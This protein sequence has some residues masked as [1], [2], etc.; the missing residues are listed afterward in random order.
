MGDSNLRIEGYAPR[1][2][3]GGGAGAVFVA[4]R[5]NRAQRFHVL[6]AAIDAADMDGAQHALT[7][8]LNFDPQL[9]HDADFSKLMRAVHDKHTY[10]AQH[11]AHEYQAKLAH[12]LEVLSSHAPHHAAPVHHAAG[13]RAGEDGLPHI[14][15][16]A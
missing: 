5:Y 8:V 9:A 15:T 1:Y 12:Q 4:P 7:A 3:G 10:A 11:F 13:V 6:F 2:Q 16:L 14:D